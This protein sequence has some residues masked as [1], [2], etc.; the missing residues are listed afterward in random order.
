MMRHLELLLK[1]REIPFDAKN[2]RINCF[3]HIINIVAQHVIKSVSKSVAADSDDAFV[4][5]PQ[6]LTRTVTPPRTFEE[7]CVFDPLGRIRKVIVAIRA[8]GQRRDDFN[9]WI[10][11]GMYIRFCGFRP[12]IIYI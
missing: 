9:S 2:N 11:M 6:A 3:P 5:E 8:S 10:R 1:E 4:F 7:A 12:K